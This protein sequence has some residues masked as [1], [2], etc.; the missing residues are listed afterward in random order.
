[1]ILC[2]KLMLI[3]NNWLGNT[4]GLPSQSHWQSNAGAQPMR[5]WRIFHLYLSSKNKVLPISLSSRMHKTLMTINSC[6]PPTQKSLS[7]FRWICGESHHLCSVSNKQQMNVFISPS[8]VISPPKSKVLPQP[9]PDYLPALPRRWVGWWLPFLLAVLC[10]AGPSAAFPIFPKA[11][12]KSL[13]CLLLTL[14]ENWDS[15]L[16]CFPQGSWDEKEEGWWKHLA[17]ICCS[18]QHWLQVAWRVFK[19]ATYFIQMD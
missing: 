12:K 18:K 6:F 16:L 15:V 2:S 11:T 10:L 4:T 9:A 1:M 14:P 5:C 13:W 3:N 17:K 19:A 7:D 8:V